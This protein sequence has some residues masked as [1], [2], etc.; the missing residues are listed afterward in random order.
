MAKKNAAV[1]K[2]Y[3]ISKNNPTMWTSRF[4]CKQSIEKIHR[5]AVDFDSIILSLK[6]PKIMLS[7]DNIF[8]D[9]TTWKR[10][11]CLVGS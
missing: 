7:I 2:I 11:G 6:V 8:P 5:T 4:D 1:T 3:K 9:D 10:L